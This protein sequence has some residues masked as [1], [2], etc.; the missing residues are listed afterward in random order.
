[1]KIKEIVM[2]RTITYE[3]ILSTLNRT[4]LKTIVVEGKDDKEIYQSIENCIEDITVS[5][6]KLD[7]RNNVIKASKE[8]SL[9]TKNNIVFLVD[10][11][12]DFILENV[13][14]LTS[15][16]NRIT[17]TEGYSIE[18][19]IILGGKDVIHRFLNEDEKRE[20]QLV[21]QKLTYWFFY[22]VINNDK[23]DECPQNTVIDLTLEEVKKKYPQCEKCECLRNNTR[24]NFESYVRGKTLLWVFG[25]IFRKP[26]RK[27]KYHESQIIDICLRG[28]SEGNQVVQSVI[29]KALQLM[30]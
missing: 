18:N 25:Y 17:T 3:E 10:K 9:S 20:L 22:Q 2:G 11:D 15:R 1:M 14:Q 27:I 21:I 5:F 30:E 12:K 4:K 13:D 29:K 6:I 28:N 24:E 23:L 16:G 7:C 8:P 26:E 19:D